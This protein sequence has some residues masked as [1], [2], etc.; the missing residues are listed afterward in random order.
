MKELLYPK[1]PVRVA[2][3]GA[4]NRSRKIYRPLFKSLGPWVE[5]VAVCDPVREHADF[6]SEALNVRAYYNI[7]DLVKD[8]IAEAAIVVT[9]IESHHSIS[10]FLSSNGIHNLVETT[11][12]STII[13]AKQMIEAARKNNVVV[14]VAENF[15]RFPID[16][17][18]QTLRDSGYIGKIKRIFTYNDHTGFHNNSRWIAFAGKHPVWLQSIEHTMKTKSFYSTPERYYQNE[19]FR[20]RIFGF[21]DNFMVID[22]AANIKGFLGRQVRPG[23]TEWHG[24]SGTLVQRGIDSTTAA[25]SYYMGGRAV[26]HRPGKHSDWEAE[27]RFCSKD[28]VPKDADPLTVDYSAGYADYV[29]GVVR[30]YDTNRRWA[31][32]YA[33]TPKGVIEYV[34]PFRPSELSDNYYPEYGSC[35]MEHI[36]DFAL[37]VRNLAAS[38]FDENDAL[39]SMMMEIGAQESSLNNGKR[40]Y[41]PLEGEPESD[42]IVLQEIRKKYKVDPLDIEAMLQ[43]CYP[44]P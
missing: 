3:I 19:T 12:C 7:H 43:I 38:E 31:R 37:A 40:V 16:R 23:F 11:W 15:F 20:L 26:L 41:L 18:A 10:V 44:K 33:E 34:N 24:E 6:M 2:L 4:G 30:E 32:I 28:D 27:V 35:V 5:I 42:S 14:R 21:E 29:S 9:P 17:F 36:V 22:Q 39:M 1:E 25:A 8:R 13:Q